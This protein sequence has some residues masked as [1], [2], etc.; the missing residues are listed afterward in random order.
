MKMDNVLTTMSTGVTSLEKEKSQYIHI[1]PNS[2]QSPLLA[3]SEGEV[4]ARCLAIKAAEFLQNTRRHLVRACPACF[5]S[6]QVTSTLVGNLGILSFEE[7][8]IYEF[9]DSAD[10][11]RASGIPE[12]L[13][14]LWADRVTL[15]RPLLFCYCCCCC[16]L[17]AFLLLLLFPVMNSQVALAAGPLSP[18]RKCFKSL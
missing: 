6:S 11:D 5:A 15:D 17:F 16:R 1:L 12:T 2:V 10:F 4:H 13:Q 3:E 18:T 8:A 14:R 9:G 7:G